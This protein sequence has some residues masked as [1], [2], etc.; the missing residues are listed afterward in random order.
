ML[1]PGRLDKLLYVPLP[2]PEER[3]HIIKTLA[4]KVNLHKD[5]DLVAIAR[6]QRAEGYSGA[7][8]SALL[9][10]A[11]LAV[12]KEQ[13]LPDGIQTSLCIRSHHFEVAFNNVLP[14]VSKIDQARYNKVRDRMA[15]AR[16]RGDETVNSDKSEY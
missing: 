9:R 15:G 14:S 6:S 5:V 4:R 13:L 1:R 10:E 8:I 2:T 11:G 16:S 12:L 7:D 3:E